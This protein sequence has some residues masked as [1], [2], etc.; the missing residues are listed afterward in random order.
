MKRLVLI[1]I[2]IAAPVVIAASVAGTGGA[3]TFTSAAGSSGAAVEWRPLAG[4]ADVPPAPAADDSA[5]VRGLTVHEWGTFTSVA[6]PD[7]TA[8]DWLPAGGPTDLPCFVSVS[9]A[10]PKGLAIAEQGGRAKM[11]KVRMETPVLY[12]YA[13]EE[14]TVNVKVSFPHGLM[15][16]WYPSGATLLPSV[17]DAHKTFPDVSSTIQWSGVKVM[18]GATATYPLDESPSHYYAARH[19][20]SAPLQVG[21]QFEKFLFYRGV[22]SFTPPVS[23]RVAADG[24]IAV[25]NLGSEPITGIVLFENRGGKIG[26]GISRNV[27]QTITLNRPEL[28]ASF[29]RLRE[30]LE[31][32]LRSQGMYAQ[33]ARAMVDTWK[34]TWFEQGTRIFYIVP[35]HS[36]DS[37]LPLEITP[38]P[39]AVARAFV[40]RM[41]VLT[42]ATQEEVRQA[43][44]K[45][46][47][48]TLEAYGR[49][50][51]PIVNSFLGQR[52]SVEDRWRAADLITSIRSDYVASAMAC[53]KKRSW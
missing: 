49:F 53:S 52:L 30:D 7:G 38:R 43:I 6:G 8:I 47:R 22:A 39:I 50:L 9:G 11:A 34:D 14:Q 37:I 29:A 36:V 10:G 31:G 3:E 23:V 24:R 25:S 27:N 32:L 41:E 45:N 2:L 5:S 40:G 35:S 4:P 16:E 33:E 26:Y 19:T 28:N 17:W 20:S 21:A 12:F 48:S 51:D 18:P 15:T 42:P 46:D 44:A 13:P 1:A